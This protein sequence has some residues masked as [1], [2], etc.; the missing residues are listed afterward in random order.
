[1]IN[2]LINVKNFL[3]FHKNHFKHLLALLLISL[4]VGTFYSLFYSPADYQQGDFVRIM[5]IHVPSAWLSL[6]IY[7]LMGLASLFYLIWRNQMMDIISRSAA[8]IGAIFC[9]ITLVTGSLWGEKTWGT[10]WAWDARLT[11]M[12]ILF[13]FYLGYIIL[14]DKTKNSFNNN[15]ASVLAVIGCINVPIV[16]FSVN[17][18]NS[19]HQGPSIIRYGGPS[20]HKSMLLPLIFMFIFFVI[21][22][23]SNLFINIKIYILASRVYRKKFNLRGNL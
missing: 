21:Y 23:L 16:K 2:K 10:W 20:I 3:E 9:L 13:F 7:L 14:A 18:W 15:A 5:Y 22:F 6:M 11:S 1:M 19:L 17:L 4:L 8:P 12:L